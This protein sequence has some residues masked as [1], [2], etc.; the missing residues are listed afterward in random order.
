M[1]RLIPWKMDERWLD[2]W[3]TFEGDAWYGWVPTGNRSKG[4]RDWLVYS[5]DRSIVLY[6]LID[7]YERQRQN[8]ARDRAYNLAAMELYTNA[9]R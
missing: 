5:D 2:P 3:I 7:Y 1:A 9:N 8:A 6:E 4:Y